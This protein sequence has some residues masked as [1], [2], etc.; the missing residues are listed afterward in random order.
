MYRLGRKKSPLDPIM[1]F[2]ASIDSC[3]IFYRVEGPLDAPA[4]VLS[5]SL[6]TDHMM[7]QTQAAALNQHFRVIR[8]DQRGHGASD[9]FHSEYKLEQ[10]GEDVLAIADKLTLEQFSL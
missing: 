1:P 8:Y 9:A 2:V 6:G 5:N 3:R 7:W 4:L 10:L